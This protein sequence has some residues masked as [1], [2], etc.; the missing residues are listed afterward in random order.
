MRELRR[1]RRTITIGRKID[2]TLS[3]GRRSSSRR[4]SGGR[5]P[6]GGESP[7]DATVGCLVVGLLGGMGFL[8]VVG[9]PLTLVLVLGVGG[10]VAG[11]ALHSNIKK[12]Q[13]RQELEERYQ[14]GDPQT[15]RAAREVA[16]SSLADSLAKHR[17]RALGSTS[18]W[19]QAAEKLES[20]VE[21]AD[22]A[23]RFWGGRIEKHPEDETATAQLKSARRLREKTGAALD[24]ANERRDKLLQ[25]YEACEERVKE[26]QRK[27]VRGT[28]AARD[29]ASKMIVSMV[30]F[31]ETALEV[32]D[33][34]ERRVIPEETLREFIEILAEKVVEAR[35]AEMEALSALS[36]SLGF[37]S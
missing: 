19:V 1:V 36:A 23:I 24:V 9:V 25:Y 32:F 33:A 4:P 7:E 34:A 8:G 26:L 35:E 10:L 5:S 31:V 20:A 37:S 13:E 16:A 28:K 3:G 21:G 11:L 6:G 17:A 18:R 30:D 29:E 15:L 22:A 12:T 2:R 27:T 14:A